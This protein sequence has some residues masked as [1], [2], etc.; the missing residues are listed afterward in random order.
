MTDKA[1]FLITLKLELK[2]LMFA[3]SDKI[4]YVAHFHALKY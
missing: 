1:D 3:F 2:L 4:A